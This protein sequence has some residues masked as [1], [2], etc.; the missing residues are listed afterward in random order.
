MPTEFLD[1]VA[2]RLP[3]LSWACG[4][5][6]DHARIERAE[7]SLGCSFGPSFTAYLARWGLLQIE[8]LEYLGLGGARADDTNAG[9]PNV[10]GY[11]LRLRATGVVP[12]HCVVVRADAGHR[13]MCLDALR[14]RGRE[15]LVTAWDPV[16]RE[17]M[18]ESS[19]D[20]AELVLDEIDEVAA[21]G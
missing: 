19:C 13:L 10:V 12:S 20:F 21:S 16:A 14:V 18:F 3:A 2:A 8:D 9:Y 5:G 4:Q 7:R 1:R 17:V 11:T 15:P 6:Q